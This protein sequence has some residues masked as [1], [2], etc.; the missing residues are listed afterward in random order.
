M[1]NW[2]YFYLFRI[3]FLGFRYHGW[4]KHSKLRSIQGMV[5]KTL[6]F[7]LNNEDFKTLGSG[8]TD[9]KVSADD[10]AF[11]LFINQKIDIEFFLKEFNKNLPSDIRAKSILEVDSSFNIIQSSKEKEYHYYF[12]FGEKSH[13]F[14]APII[15]D[16]GEYLDIE[17]MKKGASIFKGIHNFRRYASKPTENTIFERKIIKSHI[18]ENNNFTG[19][20]TPT[21]SFIYKVKSKGFLTY[22]VRLMMGALVDLGKGKWSLKDLEDS[23]TNSNEPQIRHIAPSSGLVLHKVTFDFDS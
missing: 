11:E 15:R 13:P 21:N 17:I 20:L 19:S 8:R 18:V 6:L 12:S 14:N 5:D 7:I 1:A 2:S 4:Q 16:F 3:E 9:A 10:F 22:Q 23:L